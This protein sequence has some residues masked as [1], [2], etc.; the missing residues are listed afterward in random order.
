MALLEQVLK[1]EKN[2]NDVDLARD[3]VKMFDK[4]EIFDIKLQII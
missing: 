3:L 1:K 2:F 4:T